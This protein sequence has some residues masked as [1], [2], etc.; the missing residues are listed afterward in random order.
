VCSLEIEPTK[1]KDIKQVFTM[2]FRQSKLRK[3]DWEAIEVPA[4]QAEQRI[5]NIIKNYGLKTGAP[6]AS[7]ISLLSFMR[8]S[9]GNSKANVLSGMHA[10]LFNTYFLPVIKRRNEKAKKSKSY[11][12]GVPEPLTVSLTKQVTLKK[13]DII[14]I[15]NTEGRIAE[16]SDQIFECVLLATVFQAYRSDVIEAAKAAYTLAHL[17]KLDVTHA[18]PHVLQYCTRAL[19]KLPDM[20]ATVIDNADD[21]VEQNTLLARTRPLDIY[22]HQR[23]ILTVMSIKE[24]KLVFYQAPTGTGKTLTPVALA[25][26]HPLIFVCA[27]KHVGLQLAKACISTGL[28][29]GVAFGCESPKDVRLHYFAAKDYV[30]NFRSGGIY[31]VDHDVGDKVRMIVCDVAS[32]LHAM[33]Y[34]AAFRPLEDIILYWD[35]PTISLDYDTHEFHPIIKNIWE[36]NIVH[37]IV[38]SSATLPSAHE[39]PACVAA[40]QARYKGLR[41]HTISS[42][43][44]TRTIPILGPDGHDLLP[45]TL[46]ANHT[47]AAACA[48]HCRQCPTVT[49]HLGL[50]GIARLIHAAQP[51]LA[52]ENVLSSRFPSYD[53]ITPVT[54]KQYYIDIIDMVED[55]WDAV[56]EDASWTEPPRYPSTVHVATTDAHTITS[57]PAIYLCDDPGKIARFCIQSAGIEGSVMDA[58]LDRLKYN[59]KARAEIA[60]LTKI[61][62]G[63]GKK[64]SDTAERKESRLIGDMK[65]STGKQS[66]EKIARLEASLKSASLEE[67]YVPNT[68]EHMF[69]HLKKQI[70]GA[71]TCDIPESKVREIAL[72]GVEPMWKVLIL[73]GIGAFITGMDRDY[74]NIMRELAYQQRLFCIIASTDYIY[75]TN[76]QFCH[77]YIGKD[78]TGMTAE[79]MIQ[80]LGRVGR[81]NSNAGYSVRLRDVNAV[82]KV[83]LPA[84][85]KPEVR[86]MNALFR[87]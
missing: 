48:E 72:L 83:F 66:L 20:T 64:G 33:H 61:M 29:I 7:I 13:A 38:L 47:K 18:N 82:H 11:P 78:L 5:L 27:A 59:D 62:E 50:Q 81:G 70:P 39:V 43:E 73:M 51:Y 12:R 15:G 85:E 6:E 26:Q 76:Y 31:R 68:P 69:K 8:L 10:H 1:I 34:M 71:F 17:L 35:E 14:R 25:Q 28:P 32:Y 84:R 58:L 24:P 57:G 46:Y 74:I 19:D 49:R 4:S 60:K 36:Q 65:E 53:D 86:N 9:Q 16:D 54:L 77:G 52:P 55:D 30:K 63:D 37:N 23:D 3:E 75:G 2:D 87:S 41:T 56:R 79:K 21:C 67:C 80:A 42:S 22:P 44:C 40:L 45:H